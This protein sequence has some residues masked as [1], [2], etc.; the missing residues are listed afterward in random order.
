MVASGT[1]LT[2][3]AAEVANEAVAESD[4]RPALTVAAGS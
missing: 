3:A 2:V 1:E 4:G